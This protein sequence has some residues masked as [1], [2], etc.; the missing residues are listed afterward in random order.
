MIDAINA[1]LPQTQCERCG[2]SGCKPYAAALVADDANINQCPPGGVETIH[3]LADL[4]HKPFETLNP[5]FGTHT[6]FQVATIIEKDCIGCTK[7]LDACPVDAI[8][9]ASKLMHTVISVECTGCELCVSPCPVDCIEIQ[10]TEKKYRPTLAK[11][12]YED[13]QHRLITIATDKKAQANKQKMALM[14]MMKA[15]N[16]D[17]S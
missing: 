16:A 15:R 2:Y 5:E 1:L 4:L 7:C 14:A 8:V 9:G 3:A 11:Q 6:P 13:K 17:K 10:P 12:R